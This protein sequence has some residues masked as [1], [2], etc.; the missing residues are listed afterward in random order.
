V[1]TFELV[2]E[3]VGPAVAFDVDVTDA[4]PYEFDVVLGST[5]ASS[6]SGFSAA[7]PI[8]ASGGLLFRLGATLAY[9][10]TCASTRS[11]SDRSSMDVST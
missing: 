5:V 3:N 11:W 7:D 2:V 4:L 10:E 6:P 9:R 1:I 8:P